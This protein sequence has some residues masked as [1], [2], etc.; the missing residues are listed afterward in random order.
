MFK[1][2][3]MSNVKTCLN[4]E[5]ENLNPNATFKI[6]ILIFFSNICL[7]LKRKFFGIRVFAF[8]NARQI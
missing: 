3:F 7:L 4:F 1:S 8:G 6:L 2:V 5:K